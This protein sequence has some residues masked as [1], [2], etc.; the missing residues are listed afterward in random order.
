[1]RASSASESKNK[2]TRKETATDWIK[3]ISPNKVIGDAQR[4]LK[5]AVDVLEEEIAAG[6]VAAKKLEKKVINIDEVRGTNPEELMSRVR[7]DVHDAVDIFLDAVTALTNHFS[8]LTETITKTKETATSKTPTSNIAVIKNEGKA[9]AGEN[10][11][12]PMLLTNESKNQQKIVT[13]N[14]ADLINAHGNKILQ[15]YITI[16]PSTFTL[17]PSDKKEVLI[18]I[19]VPLTCKPGIYSGL[20]QDINDID[21]KTVVTIEVE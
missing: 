13:L 1:M 17:T 16:E 5:T 10:I 15:R 2:N 14:K 6:I 18:K 4:I 3:N 7:R 8:S 12:L 21:I 11:E 9:K 20:F 19:K